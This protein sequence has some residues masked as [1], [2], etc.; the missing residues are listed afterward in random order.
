MAKVTGSNP[1]EP[2]AISSSKTY[3]P[4]GRCRSDAGPRSIP[5][6]ADRFPCAGADEPR[7]S[8]IALTHTIAI[9]A[10]HEVRCYGAMILIVPFM[11]TSGARAAAN[12]TSP[13][14][15][16]RTKNRDVPPAA[17][18]AWLYVVPLSVYVKV[19]GVSPSFRLAI[20]R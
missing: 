1:V 19:G 3:G 4:L 6:V 13:T 16:T 8:T 17:G 2:T 10:R 15:E 14:V 12:G 18:R 7:G 9:R 20:R 11:P 5:R